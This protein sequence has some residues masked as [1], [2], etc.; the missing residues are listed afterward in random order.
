[1]LDNSHQVI[2]VNQEFVNLFGYT[3]EELRDV[4]SMILLSLI[5][6]R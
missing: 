2:N 6:V 4:I 1:M 3:L 5:F